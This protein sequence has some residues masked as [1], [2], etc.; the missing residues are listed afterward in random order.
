MASLSPK[1]LDVIKALLSGSSVTAAAQTA[2]VHRSTIYEWQTESAFT[3]ALDQARRV[4]SDLLIDNIAGLTVIALDA[5]RSCL[6]EAAPPAVRLKAALQV[7]ETSANLRAP[8]LPLYKFNEDEFG[9]L[10]DACM[11]AGMRMAKEESV[12]V[13][14]TESDTSDSSPMSENI[15][16]SAPCPCGSGAKYK[17]CCGRQAPA[18]HGGLSESDTSFRVAA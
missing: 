5:L 10:M 17:R 11:N 13:N 3:A 2:G 16:R 18:V 14:P 4:R 1:Q 12:A 8:Q 9:N 15:P 6:A 7:L